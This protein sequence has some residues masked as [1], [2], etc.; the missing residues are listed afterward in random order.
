MS[1]PACLPG[2]V[3]GCA[4]VLA[5]VQ[6]GAA[7]AAGDGVAV[8]DQHAALGHERVGITWWRPTS[9]GSIARGGVQVTPLSRL[10]RIS[11]A[12]F[13]QPLPPSGAMPLK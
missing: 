13:A 5:D 12:S 2:I 3:P 1:A 6:R 11:R 7:V 4:A 8:L 9:R 10:M